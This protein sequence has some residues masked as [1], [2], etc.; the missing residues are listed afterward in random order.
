MRAGRFVYLYAG[1]LHSAKV[2]SRFH[3]NL[4]DI[5]IGSTIRQKRLT[6]GGGPIPDADSDHFYNFLTIAK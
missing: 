3:W 4:I 2:I 1:L 6:F 5:V